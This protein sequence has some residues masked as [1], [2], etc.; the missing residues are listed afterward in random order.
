MAEWS[1]SKLGLSFGDNGNTYKP[2]G[3]H[4]API[5]PTY[6]VSMHVRG[7]FAINITP[8]LGH[9]VLHC[10]GGGL[11]EGNGICQIVTFFKTFLQALAYPHIPLSFACVLLHHKHTGGYGRHVMEGCVGVH[12]LPLLWIVVHYTAKHTDWV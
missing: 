9:L 3:S 1:W 12:S 6:W 5:R 8:L 7:L 4:V 10:L 11:V 2:M